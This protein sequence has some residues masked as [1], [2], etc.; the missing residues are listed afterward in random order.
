MTC[1]DWQ[2]LCY[3]RQTRDRRQAGPR[4][5]DAGDVPG[6]QAAL[7]HLDDCPS[8]QREALAADP[9]LLFRRLPVL[10]ADADETEAMKRAVASMRR[11]ETIEHRAPASRRMLLRAA[12]LAVVLLGSALLRGAQPPMPES[13]GSPLLIGAAAALVYELEWLPL[14]EAAD[15]SYGSIIQV[16][17][18]DIS[19]VV[20]LPPDVG[21]E[22][23][24]DSEVAYPDA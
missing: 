8:C 10:S 17:D 13:V 5:A 6:W 7:R 18:D 21:G 1:P 4:Q 12:A 3:L 11:G 22:Q 19:V 24:A 15:P 16:V 23:G 14:V 20:V 9:T 2:T